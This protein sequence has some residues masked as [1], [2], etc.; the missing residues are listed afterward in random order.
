[1]PGRYFL[2]TNIF[3][4]AFDQSAPAKAKKAQQLI[5]DALRSGLGVI[6]YQVVQEFFNVA[7]RNFTQKMTVE[8]AEQFLAITLRPLL[9][10]HSSPALYS[11]ALHLHAR[12]K[13]SWFDSLIVSA[14][15]EAQCDLLYSE[16]LQHGQ[17]FGGLKVQN[18][19]R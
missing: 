5:R 4:Y 1:M 18:P 15:I 17:K 3:V 8:E 7:L 9:A 14:A 13:L 2:D 19:F 11:E 16:D 12:H 6:S 10:V